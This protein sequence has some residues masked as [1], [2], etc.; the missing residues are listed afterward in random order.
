MKKPKKI[1][2]PKIQLNVVMGCDMAKKMN[3]VK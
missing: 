2:I 3:P 1:I